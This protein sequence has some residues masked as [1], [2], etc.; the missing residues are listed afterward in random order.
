MVGTRRAC[1]HPQSPPT[2]LG[3]GHDPP[4]GSSRSLEQIRRGTLH[5]TLLQLIAEKTAWLKEKPMVGLSDRAARS[6][7]S[8]VLAALALLALLLVPGRVE[9]SN[10]QGAGISASNS[11]IH[12]VGT[13]LGT[14]C[15]NETVAL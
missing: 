7:R 12:Y 8:S 9:A 2:I 6:V 5:I 13:A 1:H 3:S 4:Y 11:P 14:G 10:P 15:V